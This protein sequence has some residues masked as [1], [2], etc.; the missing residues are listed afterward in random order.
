VSGS[1]RRFVRSARRRGDRDPRESSL[2]LDDAARLLANAS[3]RM[4]PE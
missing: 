3:G 1:G 4:Y 2:S